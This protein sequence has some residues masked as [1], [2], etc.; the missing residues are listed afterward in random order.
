MKEVIEHRED[1]FPSVLHLVR[2]KRQVRFSDE[3]TSRQ[4]RKG[5]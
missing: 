5:Y 4:Q 1:R 3:T 2:C